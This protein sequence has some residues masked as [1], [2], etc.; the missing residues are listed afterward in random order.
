MLSCF[1]NDSIETQEENYAK[2]WLHPIEF[3]FIKVIDKL[4]EDYVNSKL[5]KGFNSKR[6]ISQGVA[7]M[8]GLGEQKDL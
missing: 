7:V 4:L 8:M 6:H 2:V 5:G 3:K 1:M